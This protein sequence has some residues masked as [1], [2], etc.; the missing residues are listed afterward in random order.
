[1]CGC[2]NS[3]C[4]H[5]MQDFNSGRSECPWRLLQRYVTCICAAGGM[6]DG[7]HADTAGTMEVF[8]Q[9]VGALVHRS[10]SS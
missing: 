5:H 6:Q 4:C 9:R 8:G 10:W 3:V 1:V 7:N 2:C